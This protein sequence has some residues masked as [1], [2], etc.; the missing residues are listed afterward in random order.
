MADRWTKDKDGKQF[1]TNVIVWDSHAK[2]HVLITNGKCTLD[3]S[4]PEAFAV[5]HNHA[6]H[7]NGCLYEP[8][9]GVA[10]RPLVSF[11]PTDNSVTVQLGWT[12]RG[13]NPELLKVSESM[14]VEQFKEML[15]SPTPNGNGKKVKRHYHVAYIGRV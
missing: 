8:S 6:E 11:M 14:T 5:T 7:G 9:E 3:H 12:Y 4:S 2:E 15:S 10:V 13:L 1:G